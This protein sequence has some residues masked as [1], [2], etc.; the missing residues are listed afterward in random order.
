MKILSSGLVKTYRLLSAAAL[1]CCA[2]TACDNVIYEDE[3][4]CS[5]TYRVNFRYDRNMAWAD[6]FAHSV[7]AVHL[8]AFDTNG[9][10]AWQ[11]SESGETLKADEYSMLLDLPAGH[12]NL[13]AWCGLNESAGSENSFSV[14]E[15]CVGQTSIEELKCSLRRKHDIDDKAFT[16]MKLTPLFHGML[17]VKLPADNDGG[18]YTYTMS[19]TKDTNHIRV[20][21]QQLS[22]EPVDVNDFTFRIEDSNGLMN[23]D[24]KL[25]PDE[26][27][28]YHA[29]DVRSGTADLGI[30]DYPELGGRADTPSSHTITSVS[31]AIAD[32][33]IA[34]L[35][36]GRNAILVIDRKDGTNVAT[37]P[38]T[39]YALLLKDDSMDNQEYLDRQD[40]YALTFFL[41]EDEKWI[42]TSIII[43]SWKVVINNIKFE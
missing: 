40:E 6:A 29:Y 8:Y 4:D 2:T 1:I 34:R 22:G 13:V 35:V 21:L 41:D 15:T 32:L 28:T 11:K 42:G 33:S 20:I 38:L 23:Y 36:D 43:N 37:I 12:Y 39:D 17:D 27:I 5:V 10:L 25:L 24:N 9:I 16:D 18:D 31:V 7:N 14:P 3:G 26:N 30:N 19:L